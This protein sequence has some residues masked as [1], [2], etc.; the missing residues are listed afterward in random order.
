MNLQTQLIILGL[1]VVIG[2]ALGCKVGSALKDH[3]I[4]ALQAESQEA[5]DKNQANI[6]RYEDERDARIETA[7]QLDVER[8]RKAK[9]V[10]KVITNEIVKY[11][12]TPAAQ[13]CGLDVDGVRILNHAAIGM[14]EDSETAGATDAKAGNVTAA[15]V[16]ANVAGNYSTCNETRDQLIA[17]QSW[18]RAVTA[19]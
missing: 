11:V 19:Q 8:E 16:V 5:R 7:A 15:A 9:V 2:F 6:K 10:E 17:L 1:C 13:H 18:A 14:S 12:Q 4:V 3:Q